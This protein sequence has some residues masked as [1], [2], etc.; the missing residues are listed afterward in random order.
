MDNNP[1]IP[2][3]SPVDLAIPGVRYPRSMGRVVFFGF[4]WFL[5]FWFVVGGVFAGVSTVVAGKGANQ[6]L[7]EGYASGKSYG[8]D[9]GRKYG[10]YFFWSS[11]I[12]S[13]VGSATGAL[14]GTRHKKSAQQ[15]VAADRAKPRAG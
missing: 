7:D 11:L 1:Y 3:K 9:L 5:F 12:L 4:C 8:E 13:V 15:A 6:T 2:P 14:P 10:K